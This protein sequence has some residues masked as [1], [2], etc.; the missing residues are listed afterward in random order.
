MKNAKW[1]KRQNGRRSKF[2]ALQGHFMSK[3][4]ILGPSSSLANS[5][6][7][8]F[9]EALKCSSVDLRS[10]EPVLRPSSLP[11]NNTRRVQL[12]WPPDAWSEIRARSGFLNWQKRI[13][14]FRHE[15]FLFR[16]WPHLRF[17]VANQDTSATG[18]R[19]KNAAY[20]TLNTPRKCKKHHST[21]LLFGTVLQSS[22]GSTDSQQQVDS[23]TKP[24]RKEDLSGCSTAHP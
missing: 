21:L 20:R 7:G 6:S 2:E 4:G 23:I 14:F 18:H 8:F 10:T 17:P 11:Q 19:T 15:N 22:W 12:S 5:S 1:R 16:L 13:L 3:S 24:L 9:L